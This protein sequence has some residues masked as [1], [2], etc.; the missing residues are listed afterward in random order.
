ML[1][2]ALRPTRSRDVRSATPEAFDGSKGLGIG[3]LNRGWSATA[4]TTEIKGTE[5]ARECKAMNIL[6]TFEGRKE[7]IS[8]GVSCDRI[9]GTVSIR[10]IDCYKAF[11]RVCA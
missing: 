3:Y 10:S 4:E 8:R 6:A 1:A 2:D 7:R 5:Q 11:R 9:S